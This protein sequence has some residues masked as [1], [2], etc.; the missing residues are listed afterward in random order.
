MSEELEV[1]FENHCYECHDDLGQ[2]AGLDLMSIDMDLS[3]AASY[4]Q[5][6][7][8]YDRV[9]DGEMPPKEQDRPGADEK[10][11][12]L[13]I[14]YA[15]IRKQNEAQILQDG[16]ALARM[17]TD[18]EY[19]NTVNNLLGIERPLAEELIPNV[20]STLFANNTHEQ[21]ISQHELRRLTEV[22]GKALDVAFD[23]ALKTFFAF[24]KKYTGKDLSSKTTAQRGAFAFG[25][26]ALAYST[27]FPLMG[28]LPA[29]YIPRDGWYKITM[30]LRALNPQPNRPLWVS[31]QSGVFNSRLPAGTRLATFAVEGEAKEFTTEAFLRKA[32][33]LRIIPD[34]STIPQLRQ[35]EYKPENVFKKKSTALVI[36]GIHTLGIEREK[37]AEAQEKLFGPVPVVPARGKQPHEI[38]FGDKKPEE[39]LAF[40]VERF[41]KRAF[42]RPASASDVQ[43]YIDYALATYRRDRHFLSALKIG[44]Q[45]VLCSP[46]FLYFYERSGELDSFA[47]ANRLSYMIWGDAPD[48]ELLSLASEGK[49]HDPEVRV[50]QLRRLLADK[51]RSRHFFTV[52]VDEWLSLTDIHAT[53]PDS[54]LYPEFD[55]TLGEFMVEETRT[56]VEFLFRK[57]L[58]V[59]NVVNSHFSFLNERMS[60]HYGL[61]RLEDEKAKRFSYYPFPEDSVRGGLLTQAS[62]AKVTANGTTTSPILRGVWLLERVLGEHVYPPSSPVA[63]VEPDIRGSQD[64]H[65]QLA[66]HRDSKACAS[67]HRRIDP[68]GFALESFDPIG[69]FRTHYRV[70]GDRRGPKQGPA[71]NPS[72]QMHSGETF[73]DIREFKNLA[74][75]KPEKLARNVSKK[76]I[77]YATGAALNF[78]DREVL[79]QIIA[80]ADDENE[81]YLMGDLLEAVVAHRVFARK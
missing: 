2:E 60:H 31:L 76:L 57:N 52:F 73:A 46:R 37:Q 64:I 49:L 71:V 58:S 78:S 30:R 81:R 14:V 32:T 21:Q 44:Y 45:T 42:R 66:K 80:A 17:L 34:D 15:A 63:A 3:K 22:S 23:T 25:D 47:I 54:F 19:E 72:Y 28:K 33:V 62:I 1:F 12:F 56:F 75:A 38:Y 18:Q 11:E 36:E 79:A 70:T 69:L 16:R 74:S 59:R 35:W 65:E 6:L 26:H 9:A 48:E 13:G 77:S 61:P 68:P 51:E 8:I 55:E 27:N 41:A 10:V 20:T 43:P 24:D 5:W 67:C 50:Q 29:T 4:Q 39:V 40:L 7:R 53:T